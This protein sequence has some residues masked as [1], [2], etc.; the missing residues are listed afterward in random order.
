MTKQDEFPYEDI[1][2]LPHPSFPKHPRMSLHDRAAQ[3]SPFAALAGFEGV[4]QESARLTE[5]MVELSEE[6]KAEER[7]NI[8][9]GLN[10]ARKVVVT[11]ECDLLVLDEILGLLEQGIVSVDTVKDILSQKD[12]NMHIIMTGW[13]M[14]EQ[15]KPYVDSVTRLTTDVINETDT[16]E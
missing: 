14:P 16:E 12:E 11:Q 7:G 2:N 15:L 5:R 1:V 10:F 3:F 13:T 4:I 9:N 8:L 6:E